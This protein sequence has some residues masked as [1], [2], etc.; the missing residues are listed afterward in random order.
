VLE[1]ASPLEALALVGS[2]NSFCVDFAARTLCSGTHLDRH[3]LA[4]LP[5]PSLDAPGMGDAIPLAALR[6]NCG[7]PVFAPL[8]LEMLARFP[9]L[10]ER[11][12]QQWWA[13]TPHERL[14][15]RCV[16]DAVVAAAFGLDGADLRHILG[17]CEHP[18]EK[19]AAPSFAASL[20]PTGFWRVDKELDPELRHTVLAREAFGSLTAWGL[21]RVAEWD[22]QLPET[23]P[24]HG[25]DLPVCGRLAP[26]FLP[27]QLEADTKGSWEECKRHAEALARGGE[28]LDA[29]RRSARGVP[30]PS[31]AQ[32]LG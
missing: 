6:L 15:L 23:L 30:P 21:D 20:A 1:V 9:F 14:R 10:S 24:L 25:R 22:W 27:F 19:L 7:H 31:V 4:R 12:W 13:V 16:A 28:R 2:L 3:H 5:L 29:L 18:S 11:P 17:G 26:Q 8:W 32:L